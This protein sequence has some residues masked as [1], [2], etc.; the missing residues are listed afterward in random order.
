ML[1]VR[2]RLFGHSS[3]VTLHGNGD[4]LQHMMDP[5]LFDNW[6]DRT[7]LDSAGKILYIHCAANRFQDIAAMDRHSDCDH[8]FARND[9]YRNLTNLKWVSHVEIS[10]IVAVLISR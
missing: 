9:I 8:D 6:L 5:P 10:K 3:F 1:N 4:N 7:I 2:F